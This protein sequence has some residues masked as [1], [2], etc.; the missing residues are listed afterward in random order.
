MGQI[1]FILKNHSSRFIVVVPH[2]PLSTTNDP[3]MLSTT[4]GRKSK[5]NSF[6]HNLVAT[7]V[8]PDVTSL[9]GTKV[10]S[11]Y[12]E[13]EEQLLPASN[14]SS[15]VSSTYKVYRARWHMLAIFCTLTFTNAFLWISFAPIVTLTERF[16]GVSATYVNL[17]SALFM[18]L[19]LPGSYLA[20]YLITKYGLRTSI[21]VGAILNAVGSWVRYSSVLV[22]ANSDSSG[23]PPFFAYVLL[24]F[25]QSFPALA[26]PLFTNVPAKLAGDWFPNSERDVGTVVAALF[27]P[28]GNA[29]G[30][31]IPTLL[32]SCIVAASS[33][34]SASS[35]T[36]SLSSSSESWSVSSL[37]APSPSSNS[38]AT[39]HVCPT[40]HDVSG[41]DVLLLSQACLATASAVWAVGWFREDPP[42]PPSKSAALRAKERKKYEL[43]PT[44]L[45]LS[46]TSTIRKHMESLLSDTEFW[47][48]LVGFGLGLAVFN[49]LL[50]VLAQLIQPLY[51]NTASDIN[52][53]SDDAG[54]YG[55]VLICAG[56]V[57]AAVTGPI[58]DQTHWYRSFLKGGFVMATS[59]LL[60]MLLQLSPN[61][62]TMITIG[63]GVMGLSMMPLLPIALETA[64]ECTY[65]VPEEMSATLLMLVGNLFGL[66][67]TY[68]MQY[69]I[70]L[71]PKYHANGNNAM[72][73]YAGYLLLI[74]VGF[75]GCVIATF[76]G[77]YKRLEAEKVEEEF[78]EETTLQS[79][80]ANYSTVG[81]GRE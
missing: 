65:P 68:L 16:Y 80:M 27:N 14:P 61:N 63:M 47:K 22:A 18:V 79:D 25:G 78:D 56:L 62:Q 7:G 41:M 21:T 44:S 70:S 42:S 54:M 45:R 35:S 12:E 39:G 55:G 73:T 20:M 1:I 9:L 5:N 36:S 71:Q 15:V 2:L 19:Y 33:A 3:D 37:A 72:F 11:T 67:F 59:G 49:A 48:L 75:S 52:Q 46:P 10:G 6:S 60:F 13:Y 43:S 28:L 17:L 50:T 31:V 26:Q 69:L 38:N 64:V 66:G 24:L 53:A 77:K 58:L 23:Q 34:A 4:P 81:H 29:A 30:Q 57:G 40:S 8:D 51:G 76:K 32:V 74:V